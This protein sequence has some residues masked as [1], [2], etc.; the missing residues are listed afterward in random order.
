MKHRILAVDDEQQMLDLIDACL[1]GETYEVSA[2]TNTSK[3]L[4]RI[5]SEDIDLILLDVM[6]PYKDGWELLKEVK[7]QSRIPVIMLTALGD[8]EQVV[9]GL[10]GGADDYI[11]KP[12]E[13]KELT[14]RIEAVL[15]RIRPQEDEKTHRAKGILIK[16][17]TRE[18]FA[19][20]IPLP[21]TKK[22]FEI[23]LHFVRAPGRVF[24][25]EQLLDIVSTLGEKGM[26]RTID[27][28][29]KNI[30]EKLKQAV[31]EETFIE[32]VW[33]VGYRLPQ[34]SGHRK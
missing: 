6:M 17:E 14:A 26:D 34:E 29:V 7:Q 25:R 31:P 10:H 5:D 8:T 16:E 21:L 3:V 18:A 13:P 11:T 19:K 24:T 32:T 22:E 30:R 4:G 28:H 1:P 2:E 20:E 15:R 27:A 33:G 9:Q 23:L 12:F